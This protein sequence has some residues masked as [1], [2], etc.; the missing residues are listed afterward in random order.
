MDILLSVFTSAIFWKI[1]LLLLFFMIALFILAALTQIEYGFFISIIIMLIY[2]MYI[3]FLNPNFFGLG[4]FDP[5]IPLLIFAFFAF[6]MM[7]AGSYEHANQD[8]SRDKRYKDNDFQHTHDEE[9]RDGLASV[10]FAA[11]IS[12]IFFGT[13][14]Y[15]L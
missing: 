3:K 7:T 2:P 5:Y 13:L 6:Q 15:F 10:F 14:D 4:R 9:T 11:I 12:L 8:G 1:F